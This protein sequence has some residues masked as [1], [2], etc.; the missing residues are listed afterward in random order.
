MD[1]TRYLEIGTWKGTSLCS[2]MCNNKIT[3][4]AI[5]NWSEFGANLVVLKESFIENNYW[6][7][8]VSTL[9]K[10]NIYMYN[11]NHTETNHY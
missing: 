11:R 5:D 3:C 10:F 9:S 1:D 2:A 4:V 6:D 7:I 8:D